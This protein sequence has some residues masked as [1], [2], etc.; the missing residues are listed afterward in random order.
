MSN[1]WR[2]GDQVTSDKL[3]QGSAA[4]Q[5]FTSIGGLA[6]SKEGGRFHSAAP[7]TTFETFWVTLEEEGVYDAPLFT[8]GQR[9][10][11]KYSWTQVVFDPIN[12]LW[13]RV[14]GRGGHHA[15]DPVMNRDP[16]QPVS[17][18]IFKPDKGTTEPT[19]F[20]KYVTAI[21]PV[22]RE[23]NT[24]TLLFF[25]ADRYPGCYFYFLNREDE[26]CESIERFRVDPSNILRGAFSF[27][28]G[29]LTKTKQA[30]L[31]G[32]DPEKCKLGMGKFQTIT[33]EYDLYLGKFRMVIATG[34][35]GRWEIAGRCERVT[36]CYPSTLHPGWSC[37]GWTV[38][39]SKYGM[40]LNM[41][42]KEGLYGTNAM[43]HE[44][45]D[46]G[47]TG[48]AYE[49]FMETYY[50]END[51]QYIDEMRL[52]ILKSCL[53]RPILPGRPPIPGET[54]NGTAVLT[55]QFPKDPV[56]GHKR[57]QA[58]ISW[59]S[60]AYN[61]PNYIF[62]SG[63]FDPT[64]EA[65][66]AGSKYID[67]YW[68]Q[69]GGAAP[70]GDIDFLVEDP[71]LPM[72]T[73]SWDDEDNEEVN[74]DNLQFYYNWRWNPDPVVPD[75]GT[76][77][78]YGTFP[79]GPADK[80]GKKTPGVEVFIECEL[81]TAPIPKKIVPPLQ[82]GQVADGPDW[83]RTNTLW[84][85]IT[86]DK[87]FWIN[88]ENHPS[89]ITSSGA[90]VF[91]TRFKKAVGWSTHALMQYDIPEMTING[92]AMPLW[93]YYQQKGWDFGSSW[94]N[95]N[96]ITGRS[97]PP[98]YRLIAKREPELAYGYIMRSLNSHLNSEWQP[99]TI[100]RDTFKTEHRFQ[101]LVYSGCAGYNYTD[102]TL[103]DGVGQKGSQCIGDT[104]GY[105]ES[106]Q[107]VSNTAISG[108]VY[109]MTSKYGVRYK[110]NLWYNHGVQP[111]AGATGMVN[112]IRYVFDSDFPER[113]DSQ[114]G[115]LVPEGFSNI[116][117]YEVTDPENPIKIP[118]ISKY[119][120]PKTNAMEERDRPFPILYDSKLPDDMNGRLTPDEC[121]QGIVIPYINLSVLEV[122]I[123]LPPEDRES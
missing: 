11:Y 123:V 64:I 84:S 88:L 98:F 54:V 86:A 28:P 97:V 52:K 75:K 36:Q 2:P 67:G 108:N 35:L 71:S 87:I 31:Y 79:P 24:G 82:P 17:E 69:N 53:P 55:F 19:W 12:G 33:I 44:W 92:S 109:A 6:M 113:W 59:L 121:T 78:F 4:V 5:P 104:S 110:L 101:H 10:L 117:P 1:V 32:V 48:T 45:H 57:V 74:E 68:Y 89:E 115:E 120:N 8:A 116:I 20:G 26:A 118:L 107:Y 21:Y 94:L 46:S 23:P 49:G 72:A 7:D 100:G 27:T 38:C 47:W 85:S 93:D 60:G 63:S 76:F 30:P 81:N 122:G 29:R 14:E 73:F 106:F 56:V 96:D 105:V 111:D 99:A 65:A 112:I 3:N 58:L 103:P 41:A 61:S 50:D 18:G 102:P 40:E 90:K 91:S 77:I 70:G 42:T 66:Y 22:T 83:Q 9:V 15:V 43:D 62:L 119:R 80:Q 114:T 39:W 37:G 34:T 13:K 95:P 25:L 16:T 51:K